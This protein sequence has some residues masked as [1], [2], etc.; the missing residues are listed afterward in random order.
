VRFWAAGPEHL[1]WLTTAY[2]SGGHGAETEDGFGAVKTPAGAGD[3][4]AFAAV[5][6]T[7]GVSR[8]FG[9]TPLGRPAHPAPG[10]D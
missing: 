7:P 3:M 4:A 8:C 10:G 2:W 6:Q 1:F 9:R 5:I